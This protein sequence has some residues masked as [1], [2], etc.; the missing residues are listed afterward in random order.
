MQI[1]PRG[2][3]FGGALGTGL[4][5][6]AGLKLGQ[7]V[8]RHEQQQE[9]SQFSKTWEPILGKN[10]A[11]F[12]SNLSPDE[13]KSALQDVTSLIQLNEAP[14]SREEVSGM[15][16]LGNAPQQNPQQDFMQA[17]QNRFTNQSVGQRPQDQQGSLLSGLM[18]GQPQQ[19][20]QQEM[21][22]AQQ[23]A[24]EQQ[25]TPERAKLIENL[26]KTPQQ[27]AAA[28][29]L[30]IE[31]KKEARAE[32][33]ANLK[34]TK[35]YVDELKN[36]E[37]ASKEADLR[38]KRMETLIDQGKLPNAALWSFLSKVE[39]APLSGAGAG[40]LAGSAAGTAV[41]PGVGTVIGGTLGGLTGGLLSPF[42]G[43][44][45]SYLKTG[46]PDIEEFEKLSNEFVKNAKQYFGS[47]ITQRE[48]EMYMQTVPTLM[49]TDVGKKKIIE[50][51][52]SLN[53]LIEIEAKAARSIIRA[54]GGHAPVDIEQQVQD[55][56]G[57]K[58]DKVA[59]IFIARQ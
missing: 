11:N 40:A 34:E 54:N 13:R 38:L 56:I 9:R 47:R 24:P 28:Q 10:T 21:Q 45:K 46:S 35:Q 18:Q 29:K 50:N 12:L 3:N 43:A 5:E 44:V 30:E 20:Q 37:K 42:A 52:R 19:P 36:K 17:I 7:L 1:I 48:V 53:E 23:Q 26:F 51:I 27:K 16:S 6:L 41:L 22:Q 25:L 49:Q 32:R 15:Q 55:K 39:E 14:S 4:G 33:V 58:I 57:K 2:E 31:Q 59:K 8:K